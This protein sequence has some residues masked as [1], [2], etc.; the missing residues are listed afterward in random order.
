MISPI[1]EV[2][3]YLLSSNQLAS[4]ENVAVFKSALSGQCHE[5][6]GN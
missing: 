2:P 1:N 4:E 6:H 3:E 5:N